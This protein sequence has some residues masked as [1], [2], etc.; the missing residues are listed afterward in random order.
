MS[1]NYGETL[2]ASR[3]INGVYLRQNSLFLPSS[4]TRRRFC[5]SC[6]SGHFKVSKSGRYVIFMFLKVF[7]RFNSDFVD[8]QIV[9]AGR[10]GQIFDK[11]R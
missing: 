3:Y 6:E 7:Y 9:Q 4:P 11:C 1:P 2:A 8:K 10:T 5:T